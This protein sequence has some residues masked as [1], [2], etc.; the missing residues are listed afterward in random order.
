MKLMSLTDGTKIKDFGQIHNEKI[1]GIVITA[2]EK[3]FFTS[4]EKGKLKQWNYGGTTLVKSY[5]KITGGIF[6]L[7]F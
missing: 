4:S 7:C 1:T 3:F 2:D 5:G 6:S